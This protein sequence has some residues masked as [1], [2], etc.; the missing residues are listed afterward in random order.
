MRPKAQL[1]H[2]H[3]LDKVLTMAEAARRWNISP[4]AL[5]YAIDANLIAAKRCGRTVLVSVDSL[6]AYFAD[7][8]TNTTD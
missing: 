2:F 8:E 1:I 4:A 7:R 3:C 6:I 5:S